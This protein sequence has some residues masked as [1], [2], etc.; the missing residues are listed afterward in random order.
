VISV[1]YSAAI[2]AHEHMKVYGYVGIINVLL[3]L[4]IV[5]LLLII[6]F[7]KLTTYAFLLLLVNVIQRC[8]Y[9]YY[10]KKHF[11]ECRSKESTHD[12]DSK[13]IMKQMFSFAG[14]SFVGYMGT[15]VRDQGLNIILNLFFNVTMNAAK[16]IANQ[17]SA[18]L[19]GLSGN[20][21]MAIIPQIIKSYAAG[22]IS[23]M[24][25][26][27][28]RGCRISI[29]LISMIAIPVAICCREIL[30][31]WLG[32]IEDASIWFVRIALGVLIIDSATNPIT[33]AQQA[34][35]KIRVITIITSI[36]TV[37]CLP[38]AWI[39]LKYFE[40][41]PYSVAWVTLCSS[42]LI[43]IPR[44]IIL[45]HE[46]G[47][48]ISSFISSI[49]ARTLPALILAFIAEY[50]LYKINYFHTGI[51]PI[52]VYLITGCIIYISLA[53]LTLTKGERNAIIN[54]ISKKLRKTGN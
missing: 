18:A 27:V 29:L 50:S 26:L 47:F 5:Y 21:L 46:I 19:N 30:T 23:G 25:Q 28:I 15:S 44:I 53:A 16:G 20:F 54:L 3:K 34:T 31:I 1:P 38:A 40:L 14:W 43:L 33:T 41:N 24:T 7:D 6:P 12:T 42:C 48:N 11:E 9:T 39:W 4:A 2:V 52:I 37:L 51:F 13:G 17:V 8:Y 36:I 10:C 32:S 45:Q 49:F 22:D 35:G